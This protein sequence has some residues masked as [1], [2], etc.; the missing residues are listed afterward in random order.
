M[1]ARYAKLPGQQPNSFDTLGEVYFHEWKIRRCR[2]AFLRAH[3]LNAALLSGGDLR[4][5]AYARW[6]AGD[7]PGADQLFL[8][9]LDARAKLRDP[10]IEWEHAA[11]EFSTGRK[12]QAIA[13]IG[14]DS[15]YPV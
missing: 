2:E 11:W 14:E 10:V 4:K 13:R 15:I 3:E 7:L 1:V 8:R 9:Y 6:L 12:D 5:A